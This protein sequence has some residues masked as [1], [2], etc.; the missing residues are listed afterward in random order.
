MKSG[1]KGL[2]LFSC[3]TQLSLK[4]FLL[5]NVKMPT[6]VGILTFM[7]RSNSILCLIG[8]EGAE[9]LDIFILIRAF[10][11]SCSFEL[12]MEKV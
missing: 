2:K 5:I 3:S 4:V 10:K 8:P 11:L 9:F 7:S 12:S 1:I 6:D